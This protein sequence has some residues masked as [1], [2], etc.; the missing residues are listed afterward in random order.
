[1]TGQPHGCSARKIYFGLTNHCPTEDGSDGLSG[2]TT[3]EL[4]RSV[5]GECRFDDCSIGALTLVERYL[6]V[7]LA[8]VVF[9]EC[10]GE[11][12]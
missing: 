3:D 12:L 9:A 5:L 8:A 2:P 7:D 10:F 1:M 11:L 4:N 6:A